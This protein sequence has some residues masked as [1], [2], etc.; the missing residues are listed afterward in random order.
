M[1]K[2][3]LYLLTASLAFAMPLTAGAQAK[4]SPSVSASM[5]KISKKTISGT[6]LDENGEPLPGATVMIEGTQ[7]GTSTDM[8]GNFTILSHSPKTT[9]L[10]S[11]V[12]MKTAK[13]VLEKGYNYIQIT[14]EPSPNVMNEVV[15]TGYQSMKRENATGSF[16]T[17]TAEDLDKRYTG[18]IV[19]NLE[20]KV[21]G[22]V[23]MDN[24]V[25]GYGEDAIVIRGVG[26][27]EAKS[28]PLIVVD[29]LPIEGGLASV[30]PYDVENI[31][32]LK[33]AS[34]AAIY[35]AR[36]S[37]GVIVITTKTAKKER[38]T[39]DF[40]SDFTISE[41]QDY[42]NYN[43]ASSAELIE[44]EKY[45]FNAMRADADQNSMNSLL[46]HYD[47]GHLLDISPVTRLLIENM[48]GSLSDADLASKLDRMSR[49]NYRKEFQDVYER[50]HF[51]QQYNLA[52][53]LQGKSLNSSF[54]V[55]YMDDNLGVKN[56]NSNSLSFKYKGDLKVTNW[57]GLNFGV[58]VLNS[59]TK[60]HLGG[61]GFGILSFLPYSSMYNE[62]GSLARMELPGTY[63]GESAF[64][65]PE[66]DLKDPS[67]NLN[68]EVGRN[69]NKQRTT[70]IR[71][72]IHANFNLLPGWTASAQFQYE[73][74]HSKSKSHYE[75]DSYF[76]RDLY[77]RYTQDHEEGTWEFDPNFDW[78]DPDIDWSD[79]NLGMIYVTKLFVDH[80]IPSGGIYQ[81]R[82]IQ[83][84][85]YTFRAQTR[86][87]REIGVHSID[88]V[89]GF[90]Y[91][92]TKTV[93]DSTLLYGYDDQ[94]QNNNNL[95]TDWAFL[96]KPYG[97]SSL[98]SDYRMNGAPLSFATGNTTHR[99]YSW[100]MNANYVYDRRYSVS[101]S[102][103][104]DKTDLFG[105]DPKYRGR[106][107]WSAGAS[108]NLHNEAFMQ[109]YTW[110]N[111]L[112]IRGS[113]GLTGNIDSSV[114]SYMTGTIGVNRLNGN[115]AGTISTPP[116]DQLRWEK[117]STWN[118]G[119][120]F[121][122]WGYRLSG[123]LDYY[124]K[125][126][127]DLLTDIDVDPTTGNTQLKL[128]AG[129]MTNRGIELQLNGHII[130]ARGRNDIGLNAYF[131]IAYNKNKVTSVRH[132]PQ[133]PTS[134]LNARNLHE[135]YPIHG[136]YS[137]DFAGVITDENGITSMG[138]RDKNGEVHTDRLS[139]GVFDYDDIIFSGTLDPKISGSFTPEITWNG[140]SLSAMFNFYTGHYFR[141]NTDYY[142]N[143]GS[144]KGYTDLFASGI[145]SSALDYWRGVEGAMPNGYKTKNIQ[146]FEYSQYMNSNVHHA[147]YL[148]LRNIVLSYSFDPKLIKRI[149][150]NDLR[151]R[152]QMNN[153]CTWARNGLGIDPETVEPISGYNINRAPRSYTMS[154]FFNL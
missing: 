74:I 136:L 150:L 4:K 31:T 30:N 18:D 38:L 17:V 46:S 65:R 132:K 118:F 85:Y 76:C 70:N 40:N 51:T 135:G 141:A 54:V 3:I 79:P 13:A 60:T 71:S 143:Y 6:V 121:A 69:F 133:N 153:V 14:L 111:A 22:L 47:G 137:F 149:G 23:K 90:E 130:E 84:D 73:D 25:N 68:D 100:Y 50:T 67:F 66:L 106:P 94:T 91:R 75:K 127:S 129:N 138:W 53:R 117:T 82:S 77:N 128:N 145:P 28:S 5:D 87:N 8:D 142:G 134:Y 144:E 101:G 125:K 52:L 124:Y 147:D 55:N 110:V 103:R 115:N 63:L 109:P 95:Q 107:L 45:N 7:D 37:N 49:N 48:R 2:P 108:W 98:G 131:N 96:N 72:Y 113:Y 86:Y 64:S 105:S 99:Y 19:S 93:Y 10:V 21:P 9:L 20:G 32:V 140:F 11:Y 29:G 122:F 42:D 34:A 1:F 36:A 78:F 139:D 81:S 24:G 15:V 80:H 126:G 151:L 89:G 44:L 83:S 102:Y 57:M 43:W 154:L 12:G 27:L 119:A 62:D 41:K 112:K 148:K 59:N 104:V 33:D 26:T 88:A 58:N 152:F 120:D 123:S 56:E 92:Q 16:Q 146:G 39:I 35:G 116:N 61:N 114:T 97:V